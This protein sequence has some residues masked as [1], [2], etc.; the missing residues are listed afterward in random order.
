MIF[1][2]FQDGQEG[3]GNLSCK[4]RGNGVAHLD[5]LLRAIPEEEVVVRESLQ[6][7]GFAYRKASALHRVGMYEIVPVLGD[8]ACNG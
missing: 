1:C 5:V 2:S 3:L 8:V 7:R 6:A 4:K